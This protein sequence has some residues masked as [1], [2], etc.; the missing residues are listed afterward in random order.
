M[1]CTF[2]ASQTAHWPKSIVDTDAAVRN[3]DIQQLL[4]AK[5]SS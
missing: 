1:G 4:A 3:R 5:R 2:A